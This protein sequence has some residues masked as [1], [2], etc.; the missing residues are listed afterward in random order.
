[1][2]LFGLGGFLAGICLFFAFGPELPV[3]SMWP[4]VVGAITAILAAR[5]YRAITWAAVACLAIYLIVS[6]LTERAESSSDG[7]ASQS[8]ASGTQLP[9]SAGPEFDSIEP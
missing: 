3:G 9:A 4:L 5:F 8:Q 1:M 6:L 7:L 2:L